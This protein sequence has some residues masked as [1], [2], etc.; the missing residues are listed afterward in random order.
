[1]KISKISFKN[2]HS[3]RGEHLIDFLSGPLAE[4]GLFAI[5]GPTGSGK[6]TLL[7]VITLALYNKVPRIGAISKSVIDG[8]GGIMTRNMQ[9]C[10][11]EVEYI[12]NGKTYRSHW[13]IERNR[14]DNLN[15]RKQ[16]II[17]V[18]TGTIIE[19]GKAA[20]P[21]KNEALIGLSYDQF[22]KA[23]VLS[24]G[25]FSK[26]LQANRDERNKLLE[27]ITGAKDYRAIG[28]AVFKKYKTTADAV[29][30]QDIRLSEIELLPEEEHKELQSQ[31]K[32]LSAGK[33]GQKQALDLLKTEID[34]RKIIVKQQDLLSANQKQYEYLNQA[35]EDFKKEELLLQQH[36]KYVGHTTLIAKFEQSDK[37]FVELSADLKKQ[38]GIKEAVFNEKINLLE[39]ASLLLDKKVED[40]Q[41][42]A[43]LNTLRKEVAALKEQENLAA[44]QADLHEK[45]IK[46]LLAEVN[47]GTQRILFNEHP[48][49]FHK[50]IGPVENKV[51]QFL[52]AN[53]IE[54]EAQLVKK[55]EDSK[56]KYK[57]VADLKLA[58][59]N[60]QLELNNKSSKEEELKNSKGLV[61]T[62]QSQLKKLEDDLK[63]L[64]SEVEQL[65]KA[66]DTRKQHQSLEAHR[67]TL[68]DGE[69]CPLCGALEHPF[70]TAHPSYHMHAD[71]LKTK[72]DLLATKRELKI[73]TEAHLKTEKGK[74]DTLNAAL[75]AL[76]KALEPK[77]NAIK[78]FCDTLSIAIIKDNA[79]VTALET[80]VQADLHLIEQLKKAFTLRKVLANLK[81]ATAQWIQSFELKS[82]MQMERKQ[83]YAA[84]DCDHK[85]N[86]LLNTWTRTLEKTEN[87]KLLL[88]ELETKVKTVS[89]EREDFENQLKLILKN[90]RIES[91][92]QLKAL[93][94]T[95]K[96]AEEIRKKKQDFQLQQERLKIERDAAQKEIDTYKVLV[97]STAPVLEL[98][99]VY[100]KKE[101]EFSS[102]NERIGAI[103]TKLEANQKATE[104]QAA[105][106]EILKGLKKEASLWKTMNSL[107]GDANGKRFSNFVQD[108]TLEQLIGY[109]NLRLQDLSDRYRVDI[110]TAEEA[111]KNDSLK[112]FDSHQGDARRSINTLSG[113]ETFMVSLAMAFA[114]S[115]LAAK[116]VKIES[117]FIDEGFGTLDPDT[118]NQAITILEKMQNE[119]DKS[120]GVISHVEALKERISTQIRLEKTGAG[121]STIQIV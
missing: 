114:L 48:H 66:E 2:I 70:A 112:V 13:S 75:I 45:Q 24:Q 35:R 119:G 53:R 95:E 63:P 25:Q 43:D 5:T 55:E 106:K 32:E 6:S 51:Q 116:N 40:G 4:S 92:L 76:S 115:D 37:T 39:N 77:F 18:A 21:L 38:T 110:P 72:Q 28:A 88:S 121:Y 117:I 10:Y 74:V 118:L 78:I 8:E 99:A 120:I 81:Q 1:M 19:S 46:S 30:E 89:K 23:M 29:K 15:D 96:Q 111:D 67:A 69:A 60:Y 82:K 104:K 101:E 22:V 68:K 79:T 91:V 36:S 34:H 14:N 50:T 97:N 11:A 102:L 56:E 80:A 107:I 12:V 73:S 27:D 31:E 98:Q 20:V 58:Y 16:E 59:S 61:D 87:N 7:D 65:I 64:E 42:I 94:L 49:E 103:K 90:E 93:I 54:Y 85:V 113:G 84:D 109:T 62:Y 47:N 9:D 71:A 44:A 3:L 41:F 52:I 83:L 100:T 26:L 108:L 33:L 86:G 57:V 105:L 17:E